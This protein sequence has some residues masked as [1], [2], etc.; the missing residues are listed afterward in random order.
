[1]EKGTLYFFTGLAGAGKSTIGRL[2]YE[3]LKEKRADAILSD[4]DTG[5]QAYG[6]VQEKDYSTEARR[7]GAWNSFRWSKETTD[8]GKDVVLC[9]IAMYEDVR[10]WAREN[11]ENYKEIYIKVEWNTL[12]ERN[13]K[14]LYSPPQKDV[15]GVDLPW[16]EPKTPDVIIHND[17]QETPDEIVNRL[18]SILD[19]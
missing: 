2:F 16:D 10:S 14:G 15:V 12:L 8:Q 19:M 17:G 13:Q 3:K 5:R 7:K 11:I 6:L 1:M 4:G 9:M 18:I